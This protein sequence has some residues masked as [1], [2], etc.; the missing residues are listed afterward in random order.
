M[1]IEKKGGQP[2]L[3]ADAETEPMAA[4]LFST[5]LFDVIFVGDN[6]VFISFTAVW[7]SSDTAVSR[8]RCY[9]SSHERHIEFV[10]NP[11][12]PIS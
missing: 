5:G 12:I 8:P 9:L 11:M 3:I 10:T 7:N 2:I 1:M 4:L 6:N